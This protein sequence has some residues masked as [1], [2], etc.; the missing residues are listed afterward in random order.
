MDEL[1]IARIIAGFI[2]FNYKD[3]IYLI[4][5]PER[6]DRYIAEEIYQ[7]ALV[8]AS[9]EGLYTDH[10]INDML[11]EHGIWNDEKEELLEKLNKEIE[12]LKVNLYK[13][14]YKDKES[15]A[16]RKVLLVAKIDR[17]NLFSEK[18]SYIHIS[19]TGYA[20]TLKTKYLV[21]SSLYHQYGDRVFTKSSFWKNRSDL[22]DEAVVFYNQSKLG[23]EKLRQLAKSSVWKSYWNV[24]KSESSIF[25]IPIIDLDDERRSLIT[26]SQLYDNIAEHPEVPPDD[27]VQD[28]DALDGWMISQ[29]KERDLKKGQNSVDSSLS[30]KVKNS[31]EI[32]IVAHSQ[33]ERERIE[34]MNTPEVMAIKRS[35]QKTILEKGEVTDLE[36]ADVRRDVQLKKNS[37]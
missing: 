26:W 16:I 11:I 37:M 7:E 12:E 8:D 23:D 30:D 1:L 14:F 35:R 21:G 32:F 13:N 29:K 33:K 17:V 18:Y 10:E 15:A 25:G 19:A 2:R 9:V 4:K 31:S 36:F 28:D 24:K 6:H 20:S 27:L 3:K 22:L 5:H 34:S